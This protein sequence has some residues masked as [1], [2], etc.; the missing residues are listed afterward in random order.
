VRP[1]LTFKLEGPNL[2][3]PGGY[4]MAYR[5]AWIDGPGERPFVELQYMR[6]PGAPKTIKVDGAR[7]NVT[8]S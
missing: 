8:G 1:A 5:C 7:V 6:R 3:M 4:S 2:I